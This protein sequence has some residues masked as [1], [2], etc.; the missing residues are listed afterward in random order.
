MAM[1]SVYNLYTVLRQKLV[2]HPFPPEID[3]DLRMLIQ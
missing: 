2:G 3:V 1:Q